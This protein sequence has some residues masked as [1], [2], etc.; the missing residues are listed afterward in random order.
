[1]D[2]LEVK[3]A[4]EIVQTY[5]LIAGDLKIPGRHG[6]GQVA[7]AMVGNTLTIIMTEE[8]IAAECPPFELVELIQDHCDLVDPM[9]LSLLHTALS[10]SNIERV[11]ATFMKQG[12]HISANI[13]KTSKRNC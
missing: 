9:S 3:A 7:S 2:E 1:M 13:L 11:Y 6:K 10:D 5:T 12:I 8:S 4:T